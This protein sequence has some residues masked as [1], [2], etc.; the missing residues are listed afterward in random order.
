MKKILFSVVFL[1]LVAQ[2]IF[3]LQAGLIFNGDMQGDNNSYVGFV[4]R[5]NFGL[6]GLEIAAMPKV[7]PD[8]DF[9]SYRFVLSPSIGW[10]SPELRVFAG[11]MPHI[12]INEGQFDVSPTLW[13]IGAGST[14][15]IAENII[16]FFE[17]FAEFDITGQTEVEGFAANTMLNVGITYNFDFGF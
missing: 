12:E 9:T 16:G 4:A 6:G 3:A 14:F 11:I 15:A 5:S 10:G 1:L 17:F 7:G 13:G 2:S 8:V